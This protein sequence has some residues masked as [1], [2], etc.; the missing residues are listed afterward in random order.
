M[1]TICFKGTTE[2][3]S[4]CQWFLAGFWF[5]GAGEF[6][7]ILFGGVVVLFLGLFGFIFWFLLGFLGLFG[8]FL[9]F[10][11]CFVFCLFFCLGFFKINFLEVFSWLILWVFFEDIF[12]LKLFGGKLIYFLGFLKI[13]LVFILFLCGFLFLFCSGVL[14]GFFVWLCFDFF[15]FL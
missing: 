2:I 8:S 14:K 7:F 13:F 10:G 15:F 4:H 11:I 9:G 5:L 1:S 6:F 12:C 3:F